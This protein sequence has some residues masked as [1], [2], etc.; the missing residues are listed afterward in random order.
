MRCAGKNTLISRK[1]RPVYIKGE[2]MTGNLRYSEMLTIAAMH[3][4]FQKRFIHNAGVNYKKIR[5]V[6]PL[7]ADDK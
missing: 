4:R 5:R 1:K 7:K 3:F 6:I 2:G